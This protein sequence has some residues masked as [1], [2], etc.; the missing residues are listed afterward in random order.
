MKRAPAQRAA[1]LGLDDE[2]AAVALDMLRAVVL[3]Q[4]GARRPRSA[5]EGG[6][7]E[8]RVGLPVACAISSAHGARA[9]PRVTVEQCV[10][11]Q[12]LNLDPVFGLGLCVDRDLVQI[13]V[14]ARDLDVARDFVLAVAA[15][16]LRQ[17]LPNRERAGGDAELRELAPVAPDSAEIDAARRRSELVLLHHGD[18]RAALSQVKRRSASDEAAADDD[19]IGPHIAHMEAALDRSSTAASAPARMESGLTG[20]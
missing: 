4:G 16:Q 7:D 15:D 5:R 12:H 6:A 19:H 8:A 20:A 10:A 13:L 18:A 14:A 3:D 11:A 17:A 2:A 1:G 9:E